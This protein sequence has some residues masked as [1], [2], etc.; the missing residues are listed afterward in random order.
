MSYLFADVMIELNRYVVSGGH[1]LIQD[2]PATHLRC[3]AGST[4]YGFY[5]VQRL[6]LHV[7]EAYKL[8]LQGASGGFHRLTDE[9]IESDPY[10]KGQDQ[11]KHGS[12][13]SFH[14]DFGYGVPKYRTE[15]ILISKP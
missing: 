7:A 3:A 13:S 8:S 6:A 5:L 2:F 11:N 15:S 12:D 1:P 14:F 9:L 10:C 4:N